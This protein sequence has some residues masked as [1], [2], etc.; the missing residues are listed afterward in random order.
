[1]KTRGVRIGTANGNQ[2]SVR[3]LAFIMAGHV[4]HHMAF[5]GNDMDWVS[6]GARTSC[7]S[8]CAATLVT[9]IKTLSMFA[10]CAQA[11]RMSAYPQPEVAYKCSNE[12]CSRAQLSW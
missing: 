1:M 11:D 10:L 7:P 3:A 2:V 8:A 12:A 6:D 4:R 5:C 9:L